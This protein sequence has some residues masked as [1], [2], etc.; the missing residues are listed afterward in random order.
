MPKRGSQHHYRRARWATI[1]RETGL[2]LYRAAPF[3]A[4]AGATYAVVKGR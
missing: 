1:A 4:S 3:L 2:F